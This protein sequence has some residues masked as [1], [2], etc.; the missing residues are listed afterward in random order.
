MINKYVF[1]HIEKLSIMKYIEEMVT[2]QDIEGKRIDTICLDVTDIVRTF[3]S[4]AHVLAKFYL[5]PVHDRENIHKIY[6]SVHRTN[7]LNEKAVLSDAFFKNVSKYNVNRYVFEYFNTIAVIDDK[8]IETYD[9]L[10]EVTSNAIAII[11]ETGIAKSDL[12]MPDMNPYDYHNIHDNITA[13]QYKGYNTDIIKEW[14]KDAKSVVTNTNVRNDF[15][16]K[17]MMIDINNNSYKILMNDYVVKFTDG[18]IMIVS[19]SIFT[20]LFDKIVINEDNCYYGSDS[21]M[22]IPTTSDDI[23]ELTNIIQM[24]ITEGSELNI[25]VSAGHRRIVFAYKATAPDVKTIIRTDYYGDGDYID[26]FEKT[27]VSMKS[28]TESNKSVDY[29]VYTWIVAEDFIADMNFKVLF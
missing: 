11:I 6:H 10:D 25:D 26:I 23:H 17:D 28:N 1:S 7:E 16:V 22:K 21:I 14:I 2:V 19:E 13:M 3:T 12:Y 8:I 24:N 27:I 5:V 4:T 18:V 20:S 15:G 29:K 9:N